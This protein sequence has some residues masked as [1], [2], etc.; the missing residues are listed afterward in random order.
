MYIDGYINFDCL[1]KTHIVCAKTEFNFIAMVY[2]HTHIYPSPVYQVLEVNWTAFL[3]G[4]LPTLQSH[5]WNNGTNGECQLN[6][7][8]L[9]LLPLSLWLIGVSLAT[10]WVSW[11]LMGCPKQEFLPPPTPSHLHPI[12]PIILPILSV[13]NTDG[14]K[15]RKTHEI[16]PSEI[17]KVSY[18]NPIDI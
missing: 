18:N 16:Q 8:D 17:E 1:S 7:G 5:D 4:I 14:R 2:R 10:V 3:K 9:G 13:S 12:S 15:G 11:L 6:S